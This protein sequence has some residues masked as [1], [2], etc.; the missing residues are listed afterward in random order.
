[1]TTPEVTRF[2]QIDEEGYFKFDD[3]RVSDSEVGRDWLAS[4]R[5]DDRGRAWCEVDGELVLVEAFDEP[6]VALDIEKTPNA[7]KLTLPY[8]H[9]ENAPLDSL[10]VDEWDRFHGRTERGVPFVLSRAAQARLFNSVDEFDDESF[11][12]EG[13][14]FE[15]RPWLQEN[16][17]V[18]QSNWWSEIYRTEE[19]PRWDL[20]APSHALAKF[21]PKM[22]LPR[23]RVLVPGAGT[24][25]DAAWFA[26][27]GH[28]VTAVDFSEE[29]IARAKAKFGHLQNLKFIRAD[30]FELPDKMP[31]EFD[32]IFEHTC[33]CA[34]TPSRRA[35][36]VRAWRRLLSEKGLLM[37]VFFV[38]DKTYGPPYGS[39]EWEIRARLIKNFRPLY[40]TRLRDSLPKRLGHELFIY[41]EKLSNL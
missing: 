24:A 8:G 21:V 36:L 16:P 41:A 13:R 7:W 6:Y 35:E 40:W 4:L 38:M 18:N 9:T 32:L 17:D 37:G 10:T 30:I 26:E 12:I 27:Q 1:M 34:I 19:E 39:T 33:Y 29:A 11:T 14:R 15:T 22:K 23:M 2:I 25:N 20:G 31:G 28:I 3:I 5:M